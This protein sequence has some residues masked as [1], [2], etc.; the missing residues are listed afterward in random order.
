MP[1]HF[2]KVSHYYYFLF[3]QPAITPNQSCT[4]ISTLFIYRPTFAGISFAPQVPEIKMEPGCSKLTIPSLTRH[5]LPG[6]LPVA[7]LRSLAICFIVFCP[8]Y[9]KCLARKAVVPVKFTFNK[10]FYLLFITDSSNIFS[11]CTLILKK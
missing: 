4:S 7:T 8:Y 9:V 1:F 5:Q 2:E 6:V 11:L 3:Y 10:L